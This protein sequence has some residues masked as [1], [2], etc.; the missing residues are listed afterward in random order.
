VKF[1]AINHHGGG[2]YGYEFKCPGCASANIA[3]GFDSHVIPTTG[4]KAWQFN[5]DVERPTL[6]PSILAHETKRHDGSVFAP[7][8][9]SFVRDGRIEYLTDCGHALAG[10][11]VDLPD[12][13]P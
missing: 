13:A 9:H 5:G 7:R 1:K 6:S 11:T 10:Q 4:P 3:G 2:L 12:W 8:C